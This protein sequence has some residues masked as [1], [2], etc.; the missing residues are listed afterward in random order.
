MRN[1]NFLRYRRF[2]DSA[3]SRAII[4]GAR[5]GSVSLNFDR[6]H[7]GR[8]SIHTGAMSSSTQQHGDSTNSQQ[9]KN[10]ERFRS[11]TDTVVVDTERKAIPSGKPRMSR[12]LKRERKKQN[13]QLAQPGPGITSRPGKKSTRKLK[14]QQKQLSVA[15]NL[16]LTAQRAQFTESVHIIQ[17][18]EP[19]RHD[20]WQK[21]QQQEIAEPPTSLA[22]RIRV[23]TS[24]LPLH[25]TE[26]NKTNEKDAITNIYIK[27]LLVLDLN[28]ILCHR[29]RRRPGETPLPMSVYRRT[30]GAKIAMTPVIPRP[31]LDAFLAYLH[32]H[33]CLAIWT[34]AK[35]KTSSKL[36]RELV[37]EA[38]AQRLLFVWS[39]NNCQVEQ[40]PDSSEPTA[41][42]EIVY[43]KDLSQIWKQFPLWNISNT[44]LMDDSPDKCVA[45]EENAVHPPPL[46]G[47][48]M[49]QMPHEETKVQSDEVNV[50]KQREFFER[51]VQHWKDHPT[52]HD[53]DTECEDAAIH[54]GGGHLLFLK[55]HAVGHMGWHPDTRRL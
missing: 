16:L 30:T 25:E 37:P 47:R 27:P 51:L 40:Q 8:R 49:L 36:V 32:R 34:S 12:Q 22:K 6:H 54:N 13:A 28:G 33:F 20:Q 23:V 38:I 18:R 41:P 17:T 5:F 11:L 46:N 1:F 45:W 53:W 9:P 50:S 24:C 29:V 10:N 39:Q 2:L 55:E 21:P 52:T 43:K 14:Y 15:E 19:P 7:N 48:R 3:T 31:D 26:G 35:A 4:A 42:H 44:L